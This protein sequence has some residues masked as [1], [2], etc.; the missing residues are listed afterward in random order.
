MKISAPSLKA[1]IYDTKT[2]KLRAD[3]VRA[4]RRHGVPPPRIDTVVG[5]SARARRASGLP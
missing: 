2:G 5:L 1:E 3:Y 4:Q